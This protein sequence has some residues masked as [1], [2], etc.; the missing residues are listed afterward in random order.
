[1]TGR[2]RL[3][4]F[5][6]DGTLVDSL[7]LIVRTFHAAFE[8]NGLPPPDASAIQE[9]VGLPLAVSVRRLRPDL[10]VAVAEAVV[11][12]YL[13]L[14]AE[15]QRTAAGHP[16][17]FDGASDALD[18]LE[19]AG[20]W[21]GIVTGKSRRGLM[22]TLEHMGI[23]DRFVTLHS[24]DDG[25]GKPLPDPALAAAAAVGV[26]PSDCVVIGDTVYDI[27]MAKAAKMAAI[28][29]SWGYHAP[30][31]L[32]GAGAAVVLDSFIPLPSTALDLWAR[33][34]R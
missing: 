13:G 5:D 33:A 31:A 23:R 21:L 16:P 28:G 11:E 4:L 17:L 25:P 7:G 34:G 6:F 10:P 29:V 30:D 22:G 24:A 32:T 26:A 27:A 2:A 19:A 3:A 14:Y 20:W 12:T 1:M 15:G 8:E 9:T 18:G